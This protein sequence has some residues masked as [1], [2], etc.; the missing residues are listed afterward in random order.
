M[1]LPG[2]N[3]P[4][5]QRA[6]VAMAAEMFAIQAAEPASGYGAMADDLMCGDLMQVPTWLAL[7]LIAA[8]SASTP[9]PTLDEAAIVE[10]CARAVEALR[11]TDGCRCRPCR[12]RD[13]AYTQSAAAIRH[14]GV[15]AGAFDLAP[16]EAL[17]RATKE[18]IDALTPNAAADALADASQSISIW[19]DALEK[20]ALAEGHPPI[21]DICK[22]ATVEHAESAVLTIGNLRTIKKALNKYLQQQH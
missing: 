3:H 18:A 16:G 21:K 13:D 4:D 1:S 15:T 17:N 2:P 10:R 6:R 14:E 5:Y 9:S 11:D 20:A 8:R 22:V 12:L 19:I 7:G